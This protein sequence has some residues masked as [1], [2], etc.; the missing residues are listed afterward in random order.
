M[1]VYLFPGLPEKF[2]DKTKEQL[3]SPSAV[4]NSLK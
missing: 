3:G 1:I 2:E 4:N